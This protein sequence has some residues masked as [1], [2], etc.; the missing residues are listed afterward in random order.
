MPQPLPINVGAPGTRQPIYNSLTSTSLDVIA[1]T[2]TTAFTT[3]TRSGSTA[4]VSVYRKSIADQINK[5]RKAATPSMSCTDLERYITDIV[6]E[7]SV[8]GSGVLTVSLIDPG[9]Q[10]MKTQANGSSFISVDEYGYLWPPI[11]VNFPQ[12]ESDALWRLCA[13]K[14]SIETSNSNMQ[15]IFE[16]EIVS[17]LREHDQFTD[18]S[19]AQS[20]VNETRAEY[21]R[22]CVKTASRNPQDPSDVGI[23]FIP[24]LP[25]SAFTSN[26]LYGD[27]TS[28]PTSARVSG[29]N[30]LKKAQGYNKIVVSTTQ[31]GPQQQDNL[32]SPLS[33]PLYQQDRGV[34]ISIAD[35]AYGT[36]AASGLQ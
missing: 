2:D 8:Q 33:D 12:D 4:S 31:L 22:R 5:Q 27:Q 7:T 35:G 3:T 9:W 15:L 32:T 25:T 11:T 13:V 24:L 23:R 1:P 28:S 18:P 19:C 26:D 30:F 16:D 34:A 17:E 21:I 6:V 14:T 36:H 20:Y 10:L 29:R